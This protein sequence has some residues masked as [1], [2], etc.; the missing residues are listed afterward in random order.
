MVA[1]V[2]PIKILLRQGCGCKLHFILPILAI[3]TDHLTKSSPM[4][5]VFLV[6]CSF[7]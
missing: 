5:L 2:S 7:Q 1:R 6:F 3:K 4:S